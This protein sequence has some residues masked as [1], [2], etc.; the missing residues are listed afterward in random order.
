MAANCVDGI[1]SPPNE[2]GTAMTRKAELR[3]KVLAVTALTVTV[4]ILGG[5]SVWQPQALD[6]ATGTNLASVLEGNR[7]AVLPETNAVEGR[8]R[9]AGMFG[10]L[11]YAGLLVMVYR[12]R[13]RRYILHWSGAW[14]LMA[15]GMYVFS[16]SGNSTVGSLIISAFVLLFSTLGTALFFYCSAHSFRQ[17][18][19]YATPYW[20]YWMVIP[21]LAL[22]LTTTTEWLP[23]RFVVGGGFLLSGVIVCR[24][25]MIFM[26]EFAQRKMLGALLL[27]IKLAVV[28]GTNI[29]LGIVFSQIVTYPEMIL[30]VFLANAF[31]SLAA[32]VGMHLLVFED[33]TYDLCVSN[34]SLESAQEELRRLATTDPLTGCH[35]RRFFEQFIDR[36]L[37]RHRRYETPLSIVFV[38]INRFKIFNDEYGHD[39]GDRI[40]KHVANYLNESVREVDYVVRWG[41]DEFLLVL[42]C[43]A[44][45]AAAKV[46]AL[47]AGFED[48]LRS[49]SLP[50]DL[51][52]S[53]GFAE[54]PP[55][56][57]DIG[58]LLRE[59]DMSMYADKAGSK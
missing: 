53:I 30:M 50:A 40:L 24:A 45:E 18:R 26:A 42:T 12:Y 9:R 17:T 13:R 58:S 54:L 35:N 21:L 55:G 28:T 47:K 41:G 10:A 44:K 19:P 39:E 16:R 27:T 59:A 8:S 1:E 33:L 2:G 56:A 25:T 37:H 46:Q 7:D 5:I 4:V 32:A 49:S 38:D 36:E 20:K 48:S 52:L 23:L 51:R 15:I 43:G 6:S 22:W 29:A 57:T 31:C 3:M 34:R 14:G 11:L